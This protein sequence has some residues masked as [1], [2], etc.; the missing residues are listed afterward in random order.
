LAARVAA[1]ADALAKA[2]A[3]S[4]QSGFAKGLFMGL[5]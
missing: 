4:R 2:V 3:R 1:W 5:C